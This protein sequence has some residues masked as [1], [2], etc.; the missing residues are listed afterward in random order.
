MQFKHIGKFLQKLKRRLDENDEH[1]YALSVVLKDNDY[2]VGVNVENSTT[3]T[4][5]PSQKSSFCKLEP[6]EYNDDLDLLINKIVPLFEDILF[7]KT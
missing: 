6:K 3:K 4:Y 5:I 2:Y 7:D 1:G